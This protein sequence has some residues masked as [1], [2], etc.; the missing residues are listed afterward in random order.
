MKISIIIPCYNR[1]DYL[2]RTLESILNQTRPA[3]E[4]LVVDDGSQD[5][6]AEVTAQFAPAVRYVYRENGGLSAARNT[7]QTESSGDTLLFIDS[8]DLLLPEALAQLEATLEATPGASLAFLRAQLIDETDAV[9]SP[10]WETDDT[11]SD[12]WKR[13]LKGNFIRSAGGVLVRRTALEAAGPWDEILRA[14]EDWD[15]WLRMANNGATFVRVDTPL[16]QYRIHGNNMSGNKE[17]MIRTGR[18][19]FE[20]L[21]HRNAQNKIKRAQIQEGLALFEDWATSLNRPLA[22]ETVSEIP[23]SPPVVTEKHQRLR[24]L[25]ES[26][27]VAALYRKVP[28]KTRQQLRSL[29]GIDPKAP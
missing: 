22:T 26:T 2:P 27:G 10:L 19:M 29:F 7:G 21:L 25:I 1:A 12:P 3:D 13:L 14:S 4:V 16:F 6:T 11:V 5:N 23:P 28:L 18:M 17:L 24:G 15:M 8:D 9:I 20:G